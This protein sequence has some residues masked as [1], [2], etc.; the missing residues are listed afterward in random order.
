M[1]ALNVIPFPSAV[2]GHLRSDAAISMGCAGV[3]ETADDQ[4]P[5]AIPDQ[6]SAHLVAVATGQDRAAFS[7]LFRHFGPRVKSYLIGFGG[8]RGQVDEVLQETFSTVWM[9]AG[10]F[11]PDRASAATWIFTIAR[12]KRIDAFRRARRP[13]FDRNDPAFVPDSEPDGEA[14]ITARERVEYVTDAMADLSDEQ[15]EVLRLSFFED[16]P[17]DAIARKLGLPIGTIKSR[18][19]LA[20]GHLRTRLASKSGGLL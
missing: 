9:K 3:D 18:I 15:R 8:D 12:N 17:H 11:D 10:F 6:M 14:I 7:E 19:R 4:N 20:Y 13:E 16:Q 2:F 1:N 5:A